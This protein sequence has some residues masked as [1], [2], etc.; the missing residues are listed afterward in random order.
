M[1]VYS[2]GLI[3]SLFLS[4][5]LT[6]GLVTTA[7]AQSLPP[8]PGV[9]IIS[10]VCTQCH[11]IDYIVQASGKLTRE[12]WENAL[13]D[14]IARGAPVEEKDREVLLKYLQDNLAGK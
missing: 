3:Y 11:G 14:M 12:G 8:G 7:S 13:Y 2:K 1:V 5:M 6:G 9:E 4:M 10:V